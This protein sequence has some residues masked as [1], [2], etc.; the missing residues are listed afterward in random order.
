MYSFLVTFCNHLTIVCH[1]SVF[2]TGILFLKGGLGMDEILHE[3]E[4]RRLP[5]HS[6]SQTGSDRQTTDQKELTALGRFLAAAQA[7]YEKVHSWSS[8]TYQ[9]INTAMGGKPVLN[10]ASFLAGAAIIGITATVGVMYTPSYVVAVDGVAVGT[11]RSTAVFDQTV[12]RVEARAS[13]IL[14]Y[15]YSMDQNI[16]YD[17]ALTKR[18]ELTPVAELESY[19]FSGIDEVIKTYSLTVNGQ[20]I[21]A[22]Q[23]RAQLDAMLDAIKAPFINENTTSAEFVQPVRMASEYMPATV[24]QDLTAMQSTLT[25]NTNG[26][27]I[28][29][30]VK[31][32]TFMA[33]AYANNMTMAE[34]Q[35][36]NPDVDVNRLYIGQLLNVKEEIPFLSVRTV[37]NVTYNEAIACPVKEIPDSSMYQGESRVIDAGVPGTATVNANVTFLNGKEEERDVISTETVTEPTTRVIAV[38]T[39]ERPTWY[40]TGNFIWPVYGRINSSFGWRSIFGSYSY[41]SGIDIK[42]SYGQAIKAADGG[43]VTF[44]GYK[45]SYGNLVIIDHGNGKQTYYGHNS[46][47]KV[48][49]GDKVYQGQPIAGAGSTGRSTGN[50]CHFEVK[51]NGTSVNPMAYLP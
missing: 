20:F 47:L 21:G 43:T 41:H 38:G 34:L 36:L 7:A 23:D 50:H 45:G 3:P 42:A 22:A 6:T 12:G 26:E 46:S 4:V 27:T 29:E 9:K 5:A 13:S 32:D 14:G 25:A 33:I 35:E 44:A 49:A 15:D 40:P 31:G 19:L 24:E 8:D 37:D 1:F 16:S 18:G 39:K 28:Y 51:I 11:V 30:V 48:K 17:F 10:P 2:L